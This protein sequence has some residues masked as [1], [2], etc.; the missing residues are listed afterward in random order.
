MAVEWPAEP[1]LLLRGQTPQYTS[2]LPSTTGT[3]G[4]GRR[5]LER[6]EREMTIEM[7]RNSWEH[8]DSK[9]CCAQGNRRFIT[10]VSGDKG[11]VKANARNKDDFTL[12]YW[13][14]GVGSGSTEID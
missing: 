6:V 11:A 10:R 12:L 8:G 5:A 4:D 7:S 1:S 2:V 3:P 14:A 13:V 9:I